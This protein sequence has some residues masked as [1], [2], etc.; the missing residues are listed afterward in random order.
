MEILDWLVIGLI[1]GAVASAV[2]GDSGYGL[3]G[4][5][6][7]GI[8]GAFG[9]GWAFRELHWRAPFE[10]NANMIAVAFLGAMVI[11]IVARLVKLSAARA[12]RS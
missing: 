8:A 3:V 10:G 4:D 1:A 5:L 2:V 7:L 11:L 9:G 12:R 6:V